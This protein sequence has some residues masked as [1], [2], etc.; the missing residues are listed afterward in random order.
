MSMLSLAIQFSAAYTSTSILSTP[1]TTIP[2]LY[3]NAVA[4]DHE[5]TE[6]LP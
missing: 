1:V 5:R 6:G 3:A 2:F 4:N